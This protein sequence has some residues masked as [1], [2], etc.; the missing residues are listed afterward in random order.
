MAL[1]AFGDKA[2]PPDDKAVAATLGAAHPQWQ[3]VRQSLR[4]MCDPY[5]E[6][7]GFTAASTG[8]GLRA[9]Q[10]DRV[11]A[12]L[13]PREG[14]FLASFAL[15]EQAFAAARASGLP[16]TALAVL[17]GA[18]R[19]AEG[20]AVRI[21]VRDEADVVVVLKLAAAKLGRPPR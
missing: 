4:E 20:R 21:T 12:Y 19:Y 9:R 2:A 13:T 10:G 14:E 7:W 15:G 16:D 3:A 11:V 6:V 8:W 18:R 1:S 17:D 5:S